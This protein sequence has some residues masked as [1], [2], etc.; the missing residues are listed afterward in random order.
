MS[1]VPNEEAQHSPR[2]SFWADM[3]IASHKA[4]KEDN[5]IL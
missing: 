4:I 1:R 2:C 3:R 5:K